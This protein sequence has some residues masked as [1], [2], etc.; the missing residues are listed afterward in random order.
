MRRDLTLDGRYRLE[1]LI[2]R[3]GMGEV[4]RATDLRLG[5]AVAVKLLPTERVGD[6]QALRRFEREATAA[7]A[8]RH[9][10][11]TVVFDSGTDEASRSVYLVMELL[12]GED[13]Q[14]LLDRTPGGLAPERVR[15]F[16]AQIASALARAHEQ[17][18]VH[19]D[20]KPANVILL[21]DDELKICDFGVARLAAHSG[22]LTRGAVGTPLYMAPE[23]LSGGSVD[24]RA[25]LYSL[26]CL[27]Y[28][29]ASG[30]PPF[31][32]DTLP[33]LLYQH[34]NAA[35]RPLT[36]LR[37]GFPAD[38]EQVVM[39]CLAKD[40]AGRP[41]SAREVADALRGAAPPLPRPAVPPQG[42]PLTVAA[43]GTRFRRRIGLAAAGALAVVASA[44]TYAIA[45]QDDGRSVQPGRVPSAPST[46]AAATPPSPT[47]GPG[48]D[49]PEPVP[50]GWVLRDPS[51]HRSAGCE[52]HGTGYRLDVDAS[53]GA[54]DFCELTVT[55]LGDMAIDTT[56]TLTGSRCASL[57]TRSSGPLS[58][59][60]VLCATG[61]GFTRKWLK[62]G[63][64]EVLEENPGDGPRTGRIRLTAV[65]SGDTLTLYA[66]G[67]LFL[68][69]SDGAIGSGG[70]G[71]GS[72]VLSPGRKGSL[73]FSDLT[74][75]CA[76]G[77]A[78]C[79]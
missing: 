25:D 36:V 7:A 4:W 73:F 62:D 56:V 46:A 65:A 19:R 75:W 13:L 21:P 27:L 37:P 79:A 43:G 24:G 5:R 26:G 35:P 77:T 9:R 67:E 40:P 39:R 48:P 78:S 51:G 63:D 28:A 53:P 8:L 42:V 55:P 30:R 70:A 59:E 22:S 52:S 18:I 66:D 6:G 15:E 38:L 31:S 71:L 32:A 45:Q 58:Y 1:A 41:G 33:A 60:H 10:G 3:G 14:H 16:G 50:A 47:A 44:T 20:V 17:G 61:G 74:L 29:L 34:L 68:R 54:V 76:P 12:D 11:I 72:S 2:G 69:A 64:L 49:R 57:V 23:Q